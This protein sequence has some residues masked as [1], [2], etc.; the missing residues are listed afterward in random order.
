MGEFKCSINWCRK[1]GMIRIHPYHPSSRLALIFVLFVIGTILATSAYAGGAY[2]ASQIDQTISEP[3]I[4]HYTVPGCVLDI[5]EDAPWW[6]RAWVVGSILYRDPKVWQFMNTVG[7]WN[8]SESFDITMMDLKPQYRD[9]RI[10]GAMKSVI[11]GPQSCGHPV[12]WI[13]VNTTEGFF[14]K[15]RWIV[16]GHPEYY[17][18]G[19]GAYDI[20]VN[21]YEEKVVTIEKTSE[22]APLTWP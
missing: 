10:L 5:D 1:P 15:L 8:E 22:D 16:P 13:E 14:V 2:L 19:A 17:T 9:P 12:E 21:F 3:Q 7:E 18:P 11:K 20:V 6:K 4:K